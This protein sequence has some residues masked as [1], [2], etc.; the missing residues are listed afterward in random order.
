M[1]CSDRLII[2]RYD[3]LSRASNDAMNDTTPALTA[4]IAVLGALLLGTTKPRLWVLDGRGKDCF[5]STATLVAV[6][7]EAEDGRRDA[8]EVSKDDEGEE[9]EGMVKDEMSISRI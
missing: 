7:R 8:T 6:M 9:E 4:S 1:S 3:S 5:L 2:W